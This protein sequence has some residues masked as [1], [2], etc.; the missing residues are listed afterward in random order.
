MIKILN[1]HTGKITEVDASV[2]SRII[3]VLDTNTGE[4]HEALAI[5]EDDN[6]IKIIPLTDIID[7][8]STESRLKICTVEN[9]Q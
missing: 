2:N 9:Q 6:V 1:Q 4:L 5:Q 8:Q 3:D 7:V